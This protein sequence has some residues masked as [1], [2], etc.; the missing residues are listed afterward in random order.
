MLNAKWITR[1][2]IFFIGLLCVGPVSDSAADDATK[3]GILPFSKLVSSAVENQIGTSYSMENELATALNNKGVSVIE[4]EYPAGQEP[5]TY[6]EMEA[7]PFEIDADDFATP[8]QILS[9][10]SSRLGFDEVIFGHLEEI[11]DSLF[12]VVRVFSVSSDTIAVKEQKIKTTGLQSAEIA[13]AIE[14][15][16]VEV[17]IIVQGP[18]VGDSQFSENLLDETE[19]GDDSKTEQ[20]QQAVV[21]GVSIVQTPNSLDDFESGESDENF[22]DDRAVGYNTVADVY[23]MILEYGFYVLPSDK[24]EHQKAIDNLAQKNS[25]TRDVLIDELKYNYRLV[26]RKNFGYYREKRITSIPKGKGRFTTTLSNEEFSLCIWFDPIYTY[27][28]RTYPEAQQY[29][30]DKLSENWRIPTIKE[31]FVI[32]EFLPFGL[33]SPME[34]GYNFWS[35]T[36]TAEGENKN[37]VVRKFPIQFL[38][39][40]VVE[41]GIDF[42]S[43]SIEG[44]SRESDVALLVAVSDAACRP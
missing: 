14:N 6:E 3:I 36:P 5:F 29:L 18:Q 2:Y 42:D 20:G 23:R 40:S 24:F 30:N 28:F 4:A 19:S 44:V 22:G 15:L 16:A 39:R 10:I 11:S 7:P 34:T 8:E 1:I 27:K 32:T 25:I 9:G 12:L 21:P 31:L 43:V 17:K 33:N 38:E 26:D 13:D 35:S 41:Y 37:W